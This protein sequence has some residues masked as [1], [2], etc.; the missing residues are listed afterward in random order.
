LTQ[1]DL[2]RRY[3]A[4]WKAGA[5]PVG[6]GIVGDWVLQL[7][8]ERLLLNPVAQRWFCFD[9]AHDEWLDTG[10]VAGEA[11]FV[12]LGA[13]L[14]AKRA[15][16]GNEVLLPLEERIER[17]GSRVVAALDGELIGPMDFE[18]AQTFAAAGPA[19]ALHVWTT[20]TPCWTLLQARAAVPEHADSFRRQ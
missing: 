15:L 8:G 19:P 11:I 1:Y 6:S 7:D 12:S 10:I 13:V 14:G 16:W 18:R 2:E 4:W 9:V 5:D 17:V 20:R 3:A